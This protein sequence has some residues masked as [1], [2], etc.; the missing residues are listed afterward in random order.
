M[1]L[2]NILRVDAHLHRRLPADSELCQAI[3]VLARAHQDAIWR[4]TTA[5]HQ[6]RSLLREFYPTFLATFTGRFPLSIASPE[7]RAVLAIAPT[8]TVALKLLAGV[9]NIGLDASSAK[10]CRFHLAISANGASGHLVHPV[11]P[12]FAYQPRLPSASVP[13]GQVRRD[14]PRDHPSCPIGCDSRANNSGVR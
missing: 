13:R 1:T 11:E 12:R 14:R 9:R 3:A 10:S 7:A 2:A 4:R 5:H 6:L 8:P